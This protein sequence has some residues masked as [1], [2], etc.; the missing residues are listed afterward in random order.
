MIFFAN[1]V[2]YKAVAP[3]QPPFPFQLNLKPLLYD[4]RSI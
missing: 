2:Q 3:G 4:W 1:I